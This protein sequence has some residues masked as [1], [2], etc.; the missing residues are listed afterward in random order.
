MSEKNQRRSVSRS[1]DNKPLGA[2]CRS[3]DFAAPS[4][5]KKKLDPETTPLSAP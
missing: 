2:L 5:R 3:V 1:V 4:A